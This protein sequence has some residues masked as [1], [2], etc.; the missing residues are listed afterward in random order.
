MIIYKMINSFMIKLLLIS[1]F[2]WN[3]FREHFVD[4]KCFLNCNKVKKMGI[5][6]V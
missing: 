3:I 5:N 2:L 4:I 6:K 1:I